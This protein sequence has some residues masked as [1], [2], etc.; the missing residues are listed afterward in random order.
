MD[1]A[2][3]LGFIVLALVIVGSI[4]GIVALARIQR[5]VKDLQNLRNQL[6]ALEHDLRK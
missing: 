2:F 3:F 4:C 5:L 1:Q 6:R